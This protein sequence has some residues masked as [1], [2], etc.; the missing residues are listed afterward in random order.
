MLCYAGI[1][2]GTEI[3]YRI[4]LEANKKGHCI[5]F[6]VLYYC[7]KRE[8][9]EIKE[10]IGYKEGEFIRTYLPILNTQIPQQENW[11][12]YKT[13]KIDIENILKNI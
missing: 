1:K 6:D 5:S 7:K 2:Q 10:D 3:K 12:N 13:K 11:K 9:Q 8:Y 4:L